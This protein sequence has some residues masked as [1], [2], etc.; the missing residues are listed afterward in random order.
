MTDLE[1]IFGMLGE[2][3]TTEIARS[4]DAQGFG[5]NKTA[6]VKGGGIAGDARKKLEQETGEKV[7]TPENYL[8]QAG[9]AKRVTRKKEK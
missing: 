6:A 9:R 8:E 7:V 2:G 4:K 3:A 1:L 5:E